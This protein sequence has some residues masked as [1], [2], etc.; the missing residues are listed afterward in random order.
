MSDLFLFIV[1]NLLDEVIP[2][3]VNRTD[4][5]KDSSEAEDAHHGDGDVFEVEVP[6]TDPAGDS[7]EGPDDTEAKQSARQGDGGG[8]EVLLG[9]GDQV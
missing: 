7:L 1:Q 8:E 9:K 3:I 6:V 5:N 2:H 4:D